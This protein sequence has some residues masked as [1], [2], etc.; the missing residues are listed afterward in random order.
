MTAN[1]S[2]GVDRPSV[3]CFSVHCDASASVLP[4]VV[5]VFA[6]HGLVPS[7]M[8][9]CLT[10]VG[11]EEMQIDLQ[12]DGLDLSATERLAAALRRVVGVGVVLTSE[13]RLRQ[14]A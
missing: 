2:A 8:H 7:S 1:C 10:G 4:C 11:A 3:A 6:K 14:T 13:K 12:V 9:S 5:G